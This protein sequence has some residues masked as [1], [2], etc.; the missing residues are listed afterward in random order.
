V[1]DHLWLVRPCRDGGCDYVRFLP[2]QET[3][4]VHEGSHLPPQMPLLKHR[5]WLAAE[6][7]EARRRDLQQEDGY[8]FSEP[9]F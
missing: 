9:L 3:V 8:Q 2:R 5:H 4:E 7:A 1:P 6:E